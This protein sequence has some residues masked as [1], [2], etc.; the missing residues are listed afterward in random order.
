MVRDAARLGFPVLVRP[1]WCAALMRQ[2]TGIRHRERGPIPCALDP[3]G[4]PPVV[5][6]RPKPHLLR[7]GTGRQVDSGGAVGAPRMLAG[8]EW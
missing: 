2:G 3:R 7:R 6:C 5:I 4:H 1:G 8:W